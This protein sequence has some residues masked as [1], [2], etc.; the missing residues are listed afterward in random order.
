MNTYYDEKVISEK[1]QNLTAITED[2]LKEC[3]IPMTLKGYDYLCHAIIMVIRDAEN[4]HALTKIVYPAIAKQFST[5]V[6]AVER[7]M[8]TAITLSFQRGDPRLLRKLLG[9]ISASKTKPT[10]GE[11]ISAAARHIKTEFLL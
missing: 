8:R 2:L 4:I 9:P 11:F 7:N 10:N 5:G 3:G 6:S 1:P